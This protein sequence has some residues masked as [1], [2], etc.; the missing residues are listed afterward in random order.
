MPGYAGGMFGPKINTVFRSRWNALF[1]GAGIMMTAYCSVPDQN[2]VR[3]SQKLMQSVA[4]IRNG[5]E[6][7]PKHVNPWALDKA[8]GQSAANQGQDQGFRQAE[9]TMKNAAKV[10]SVLEG[11]GAE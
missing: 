8:G 11:R 5:A 1:W 4:S 3:G 6:S 10:A 9:A 2:G 7:K